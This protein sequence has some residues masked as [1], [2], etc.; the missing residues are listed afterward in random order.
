MTGTSSRE[1]ENRQ[2][3][4]TIGE[5]LL[6][7]RLAPAPGNYALIFHV[8]TEPTSPAAKAFAALT[9]DGLR[10][11]QRDADRLREQFDVGI[12]TAMPPDTGES[13]AAARRQIEDFASIVEATRVEAQAYGA[14]LA[15][16]AAELGGY[17]HPAIAQVA[18]ITGEM[19]ERTR[20][21]EAQL[22]AARQEARALRERLAEA[23]DEARRDPLT[24]LPNRRAFEDRLAELLPQGGEITLAICDIDHFK[25]INDTHGH[26][27]GDRVLRMV[28]EVLGANCGPHMV[29]RIGGEEFVVLFEG[30][31]PPVAAGLLDGARTDLAGRNFKVRGTDQPIGRITFSAGVARCAAKDGEAPLKRADDLLY[32]AKNSGRNKVMVEAG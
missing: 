8:T 1:A 22:D 5:F 2:L 27:V 25:S 6:A 26:G 10:L 23:E 12:G 32:K 20:A 19:L 29:A 7:H 24:R 15:R 21:T 28:G 11:S 4:R 17:D 3:Y 9:G 13:L 16:G 31:E 14:D 18:R 30:V